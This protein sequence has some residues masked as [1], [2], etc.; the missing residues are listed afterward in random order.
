[1]SDK[2][3]TVTIT[4]SDLRYILRS[5]DTGMSEIEA[6]VA[7]GLLDSSVLIDMDSASNILQDALKQ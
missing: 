6:A 2:M 5:L 4:K 1:M 3:D 7:D